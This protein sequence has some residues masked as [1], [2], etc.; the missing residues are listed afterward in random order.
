M[1]LCGSL[2][3]ALSLPDALSLFLSGML[4]KPLLGSQGPCSTPSATGALE[5]FILVCRWVSLLLLSTHLRSDQFCRICFAAHL[6]RTSGEKTPSDETPLPHE[7]CVTVINGRRSSASHLRPRMSPPCHLRE[8][9]SVDQTV[10]GKVQILVRRAIA[11]AGQPMTC[12]HRGST[13]P[14]PEKS[15]TIKFHSE[16]A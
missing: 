2:S 10:L 13:R 5:H 16:S 1:A 15:V 11:S 3:L 4:T 12:L 14:F 8:S 6:Q 7:C 9:D